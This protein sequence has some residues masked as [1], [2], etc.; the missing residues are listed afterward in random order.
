MAGVLLSISGVDRDSSHGAISPA[1]RNCAER[2][3]AMILNLLAQKMVLWMRIANVCPSKK[4]YCVAN[5]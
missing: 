3:S 5:D 1:V 4:A 2:R